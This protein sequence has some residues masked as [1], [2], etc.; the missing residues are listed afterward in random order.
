MV[1]YPGVQ[2]RAQEELE[3]IVG[4]S[5]LP[6]FSDRA[7]LPYVDALCKEC[8]RWQPV[9]PLGVA[10]KNIDVDE[11]KGYRIPAG[12]AIFQNTW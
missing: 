3:K 11:Y 1:L 4:P 5:R 7:S 2:K 12:S 6:E 9:L 10:H 8:L